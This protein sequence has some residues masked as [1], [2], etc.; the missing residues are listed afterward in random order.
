MVGKKEKQNL[1]DIPLMNF[2]AIARRSIKEH[3]HPRTWAFSFVA[4][5]LESNKPE[6]YVDLVHDMLR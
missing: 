4:V 1:K 5:W 2:V 3:E 6:V